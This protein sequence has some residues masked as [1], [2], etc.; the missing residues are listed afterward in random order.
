MLVTHDI[1]EAVRLATQVAVMSARPGRIER[2]VDTGFTARDEY[3]ER[4]ASVRFLDKVQ[5]LRAIF[6]AKARSQP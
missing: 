3:T 4:I 2:L 1:A 6:L 5:E